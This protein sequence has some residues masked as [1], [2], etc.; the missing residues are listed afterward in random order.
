MLTSL[1][2]VF[3]YGIESDPTETALCRHQAPAYLTRLA[4]V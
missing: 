4:A 1:S 3:Q 2:G